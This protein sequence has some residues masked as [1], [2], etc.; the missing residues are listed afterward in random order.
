[1]QIIHYLK[2]V[3]FRV[4]LSIILFCFVFMNPF[5][6]QVLGISLEDNVVVEHLR[7]KVSK[8]TREAWLKAE[9]RSWGPWLIDQHGFLD[10]KLLWEEGSEE[11]IILITW[12]SR[13][14]WKTISA[15]EL[16]KVQAKF[17]EIAREETGVLSGNPF[18]L[19]FEG[20][21]KS[22]S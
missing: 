18:P 21:L 7:L 19:T 2:R 11:A 22:F 17:E 15:D 14:D 6:N 10:R 8:N 20:E 1:M 4:V 12:A 13:N 5:S 9:S 3:I 16:E